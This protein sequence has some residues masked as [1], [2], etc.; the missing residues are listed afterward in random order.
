MKNVVTKLELEAKLLKSKGCYRL[1]SNLGVRYVVR[2]LER[3][4]ECRTDADVGIACGK[5][6]RKVYLVNKCVKTDI[7]FPT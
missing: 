4:V 6:E 1:A 7:K 3:E 5:I 2:T